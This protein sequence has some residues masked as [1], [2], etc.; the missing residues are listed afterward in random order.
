MTHHPFLTAQWKY[1]AMINYE[2]DKSILNPFI[3]QGTEID[4]WKG[5]AYIS[6]VGFMFLDTR[7]KGFT[8]PFHRNF[9][10]VNL[11][12]YVRKNEDGRR[13]VVFIKEIVPRQAIAYLARR[14]Y[15][16]NYVALPMKHQ[17]IVEQST[18]SAKYQWKFNEKWH[19]MAL[20]CKGEPYFPLAESEEEFI[21]EHYWGYSIQRDGR[22]MEYQVKHPPWRIWK[23]EDFNVTVDMES[24]YGPAFAP[25]LQTRPASVFLAEGSDIQVF[26]GSY[27]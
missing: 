20:Q 27:C 15:N 16:E 5:K 10:E 14:L 12:F 22:T 24:L 23:A 3:P 25:F 4:L 26:K 1:L 11:R 8:I 9:E 2:I 18:V 7:V 6:L 21:T 13:G 17:I 19:S